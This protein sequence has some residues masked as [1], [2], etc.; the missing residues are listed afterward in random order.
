MEKINELI[1][2]YGEGSNVVAPAMTIYIG[3]AHPIDE[4][5]LP[6]SLV[7]QDFASTGGNFIS[8]HSNLEARVSAAKLLLKRK[9]LKG[10]L[11]CDSMR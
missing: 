6:N 1:G 8:L 11:V 7:E 4:W 10:E 3:E 5:R 2:R 9:E